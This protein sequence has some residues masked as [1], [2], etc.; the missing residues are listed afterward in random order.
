M[1]FIEVLEHFLSIISTSFLL[2]ICLSLKLSEKAV[3]RTMAFSFHRELPLVINTILKRVE[4]L[5][6]YHPSI[7]NQN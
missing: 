7:T 4:L 2:L 6:V 1:F 3:A 5:N